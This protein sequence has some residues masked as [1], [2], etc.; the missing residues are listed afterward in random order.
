MTN[1]I[2]WFNGRFTT[3]DERVLGVE[4]G[5][6]GRPQ[7][8]SAGRGIECHPDLM[9]VV[10]SFHP[11]VGKPLLYHPGAAQRGR[12]AD[13]RATPRTEGEHCTQRGARMKFELTRDQRDFASA[14]EG[15]LADAHPATA[16]G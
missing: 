2:L 6:Q 10:P 7:Q 5:G 9:L 8:P 4:E 14:L 16:E 11:G 12:R 13:P 15:L 1:D 3:T